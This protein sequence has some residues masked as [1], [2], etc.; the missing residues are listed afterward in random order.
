MESFN[1]YLINVNLN[2]RVNVLIYYFN[3]SLINVEIYTL[4]MLWLNY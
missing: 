3:N 2:I 1:N 4:K